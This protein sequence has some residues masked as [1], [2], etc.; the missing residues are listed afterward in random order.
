MYRWFGVGKLP[1]EL[2]ATL[3]TAVLVEEGVAITLRRDFETPHR[4]ARGSVRRE[5]GALAIFPSRIVVVIRGVVVAG[6]VVAEDVPA[7][8]RYEVGPESMDVT[9]DVGLLDGVG[10]GTIRLT[11]WWPLSAAALAA[12]PAR[13]GLR[14]QASPQLTRMP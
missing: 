3:D 9:V 12:I 8:G 13:G 4:V 2:R 6:V 11:C 1:P 14:L 10:S 7:S 5:V